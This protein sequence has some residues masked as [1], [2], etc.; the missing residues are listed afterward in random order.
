MFV[1]PNAANAAGTLYIIEALQSAGTCPSVRSDTG[2]TF[3]G[4][5]IA[6]GWMVS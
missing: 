4:A 2:P 3:I 6:A 5:G 1:A